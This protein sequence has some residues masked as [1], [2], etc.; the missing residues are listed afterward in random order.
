MRLP[1]GGGDPDHSSASRP[2]VVVGYRVDKD[3]DG[4][5]VYKAV[6]ED[7]AVLRARAQLSPDNPAVRSGTNGTDFYG[8]EEA[9]RFVFRENLYRTL[10]E[11]GCSHEGAAY[12]LQKWDASRHPMLPAK[13]RRAW[14]LFGED[15]A[16]AVESFPE[17][18]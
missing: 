13:L 14:E 15:A 7:Q 18:R 5:W 9:R 16:E 3:R 10:V 17:L 1:V 6:L 11:R 8:E 2:L 4:W 12:W